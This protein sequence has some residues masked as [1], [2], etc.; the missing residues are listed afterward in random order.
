MVSQDGQA[1]V[2]VCQGTSISSAR[3]QDFL[4]A[5]RGSPAPVYG[6]VFVEKV[7][8]FQISV[9]SAV[10]CKGDEVATL[11]VSSWRVRG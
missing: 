6:N 11:C 4:L 1:S 7:G 8:H 3:E 9:P 10:D 2:P 5:E